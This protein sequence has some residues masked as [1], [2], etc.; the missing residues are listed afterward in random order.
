MR[1]GLWRNDPYGK[2]KLLEVGPEKGPTCPS[3][4]LDEE[5]ERVFLVVVAGT[6][7]QYT[8]Q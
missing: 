6:K 1:V 4:G 8:L 2:H 5:R 7:K 3:L